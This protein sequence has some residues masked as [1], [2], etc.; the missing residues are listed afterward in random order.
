GPSAGGLGHQVPF[1][2]DLARLALFPGRIK[3]RAHQSAVLIGDAL[4]RDFAPVDG[5]AQIPRSEGGPFRQ[6]HFHRTKRPIAGVVEAIDNSYVK[7]SA[8]SLIGHCVNFSLAID[9]PEART[10]WLHAT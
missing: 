4:R 5:H 1:S 6:P 8:I 7:P 3:R 9:E 2:D 10:Q